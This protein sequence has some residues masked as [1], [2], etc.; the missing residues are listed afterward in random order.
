MIK[1]ESCRYKRRRGKRRVWSSHKES[2]DDES[3]L[4]VT[5]VTS[6]VTG[7]MSIFLHSGHLYSMNVI[8]DFS[9][10]V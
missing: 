6:L 4:W 9:S 10:S 8:D 5:C 2:R 7:P 3:P 1:C